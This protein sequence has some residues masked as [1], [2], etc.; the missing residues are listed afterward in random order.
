MDILLYFGGPALIAFLIQFLVGCR[1]QHKI[2][3]YIPIYCFVITLAFAIIALTSDSGFFLG[4]NVI[5]ALVWCIIGVCFLIGYALAIFVFV[6]YG[7]VGN[8]YT[9]NNDDQRSSEVFLEYRIA[10]DNGQW[11]A[12]EINI[13]VSLKLKDGTTLEKELL[14]CPTYDSTTRNVEISVKDAEK[15]NG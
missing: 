5:A 8:T 6:I 3:R 1:T 7:Y 9:V 13:T 14:V 12:D 15:W 4:G 10:D 11:S 2:L